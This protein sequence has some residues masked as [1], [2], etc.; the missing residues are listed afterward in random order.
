MSSG[1]AF[2]TLKVWHSVEIIFRSSW[3]YHLFLEAK[4]CQDFLLSNMI[5]LLFSSHVLENF[6]VTF[7]KVCDVRGHPQFSVFWIERPLS[8]YE[9][10][11]RPHRWSW[12]PIVPG[13]SKSLR[14]LDQRVPIGSQNHHIRW[15]H[16]LGQLG[17]MGTQPSSLGWG[18]QL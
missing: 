10:D 3:C 11:R 18:Y 17:R 5:C 1:L 12:A 15:F 16:L 8:K 14:R 4:D 7:H 9:Q 6:Q 13:G 2:F